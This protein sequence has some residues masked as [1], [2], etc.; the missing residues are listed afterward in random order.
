M[1]THIA[2]IF[3]LTTTA[4]TTCLNAQG[5]GQHDAFKAWDS[6]GDGK[7]SRQ[8]FPARFE[9]GLF[10]R[11]DSN[12]DDFLSPQE[13]SDFRNRLRHRNNRKQA[14]SKKGSRLPEGIELTANIT[15][16][17]IESR[18]L[19]LDLYAPKTKPSKPMPVVMWIH[20]GGW[21]SGSKNNPRQALAMLQRGYILVSVEYRLSG[22]A[23]FPAAIADCK[24]A[25]RWV[26]AN[27]KTYGMDP[28]RVGAWGS[29]AGGH[30]VALL[31]T[32][33]DVKQWDAIHEENANFS[34]RPNAICDWF[35]PTDFLR[36]NDFP[37]NI[38]HDAADSPESRFIGAAIQTVPIQTQL[39]NPIKYISSQTPPFLI[40]HGSNDLAVCYNQSEL[41]HSAL[42]KS[43]VT[44]KLYKV[45][46]GGHGF[47]NA[48]N[49]TPESL[50]KMSADFFDKQFLSPKK[51]HD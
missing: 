48:K 34:S 21:K 49:D 14:D 39:A 11:V 38:D 36:M 40:L 28:K 4:I 17:T 50:F 22:E 42:I 51:Q 13:D 10:D 16:A 26:R 27:A 6:N 3:A 24:A 44:S 7:V 35:G 31:G 12:G 33:G 30:L 19:K 25:V 18:E 9:A 45:V 43:R 23:T 15:Y 8:E 20:G 32:A 29:S 46:G 47:R 41:L 2:F 1:R 5:Q 37:S